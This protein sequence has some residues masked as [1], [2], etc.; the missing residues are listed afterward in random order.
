[1]RLPLRNAGP[2]YSVASGTASE[3]R[4]APKS[5]VCSSSNR[6]SMPRL[7]RPRRASS[8]TLSPTM[9]RSQTSSCTR[10]GMSSSRTSRT[11]SGMF[12]P[13]NISWSLPRLYLRPQRCSS[14]SELSVSRPLFCTAIFRRV[15]LS[16]TCLLALAEG[17]EC[18]LIAAVSGIEVARDPADG[19]HAD[20]GET[21]DLA[22]G[23]VA[24][25]HLGDHPA[26]GHRL[27]LGGRAQVT[28]EVAHVL[29]RA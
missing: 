15:A 18:P 6:G 17:P 19:R 7:T 22:V 16:I 29:D 1:M 3:S 27:Q 10:S 4:Q 26:V 24:L 2:L 25:E 20:P 11:S 28:E 12:S 14:S 9:P 23:E 13:K 8:M 5:S 21:M